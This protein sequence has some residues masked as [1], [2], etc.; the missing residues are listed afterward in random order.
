MQQII[1]ILGWLLMLAGTYVIG[2]SYIRQIKN[3]KNLK[4]PEIVPSSPAPFIGP[5]LVTIG[6]Y[7]SPIGFSSWYLLI[8]AMDPDTVIVIPGLPVVFREMF[9]R[10]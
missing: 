10:S 9:R 6:L 2:C 8:F 1:E 7:L 5:I 3:F 4:H